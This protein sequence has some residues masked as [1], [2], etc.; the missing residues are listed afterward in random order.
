MTAI[1][2]WLRSPVWWGGVAT[3]LL[4]G[5]GLLAWRAWGMPVWLTSALSFC[6]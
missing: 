5:A 1:R 6:Y 2:H 3:V 4:G